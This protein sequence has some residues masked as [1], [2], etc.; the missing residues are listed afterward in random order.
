MVDRCPT[1][2]RKLDFET[3]GNGH[4]IAYHPM[5]KCIPPVYKPAAVQ[6]P[7]VMCGK[8]VPESRPGSYHRTCKQECARALAAQEK[9]R[10]YWQRQGEIADRRKVLAKKA[11]RKDRDSQL[12]L[13]IEEVA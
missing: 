3:D 1:C 10:K 6:P 8:P 12:S 7:C 13:E 9:L 5:G 2:K 4:V 11:A